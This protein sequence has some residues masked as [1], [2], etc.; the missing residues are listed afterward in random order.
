MLEVSFF[1]RF[2][3]GNISHFLENVFSVKLNVAR[4]E[5]IIN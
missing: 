1:K 2:I 5:G 3:F 4:R